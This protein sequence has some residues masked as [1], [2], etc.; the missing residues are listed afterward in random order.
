MKADETSGVV[1]LYVPNHKSAFT[2]TTGVHV[3]YEPVVEVFALLAAVVDG[4]WR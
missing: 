1:E 3:N 4:D 2:Q